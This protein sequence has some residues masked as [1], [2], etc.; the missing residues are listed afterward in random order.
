MNAAGDNLAGRHVTVMGLGRHGGGVST[1]RF[2][3]EQGARVTITDTAP[4]GILAESLQAIRDIQLEDIRLGAHS[5]EA[6]RNAELVIVNPAVRPGNCWVE[7]ARANGIPI[8]SEIELFL[9]RVSGPVIGVTGSNGKSTT[10][11][12][13]AAILTAAGRTAW[14]GGNIERSLLPHLPQMKPDDW[15]VLE[16]SSF[17]LHWLS[18]E[19]RLPEITVITNCT[20]N[21][22][23]W[24]KNY[25]HYAA[26]KRR[27]LATGSGKL[28][29]SSAAV[30]VLGSTLTPW[31][32][33]CV[34]DVVSIDETSVP[35]LL[36]PGRH[37]R[38]NA[39]CAG[40][41]ARAVGCDEGAIA[42]ALS[43]F[44]GLPHRLETIAVVAGR[45]MI[46]DTQATTPEATIAALQSIREPIWLLCG[47]ANKGATF[48]NLA[49]VIKSH[50]AGAACY[51]A[52]GPQI[53]QAIQRCGA[54][55]Q[56]VCVERL[57]EA[58][59]WCWERSLPGHSILL[60]PAC[61]STDQ[62]RDYS[63]RAEDFCTL[64]RSASVDVRGN[65]R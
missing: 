13:I 53:H 24:H 38:E 37:N 41:A 1:A 15:T 65:P 14:L 3:V 12:M 30:A 60:S 36:I 57:N 25:N 9:A 5:H 46:N 56:N 64:A 44:T 34:R 35:P 6:F 8:T 47:G 51:G 50:C 10:A 11:S 52:V 26:A 45:R 43:S 61:A 18:D 39:A 49:E 31:R 16:L 59:A 48:H 33:D 17:Q 4:A 55:L 29:G 32:A 23:D 27:L 58:F 40:A 19:T 20:P 22:L 42:N 21:H 2:L 7:Q 62:Y 28:R 54:H 63:H